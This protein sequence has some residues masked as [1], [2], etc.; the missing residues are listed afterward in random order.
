MSIEELKK[1][2]RDNGAGDYRPAKEAAEL[3]Q[4]LEDALRE[5]EKFG[6]SKGH[7]CGYTCADYANR[8]L[9]ANARLE[10]Q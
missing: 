6:H 7:G 5:I 1:W 2:L 4:R 10:G 3:I 9:S 8:A